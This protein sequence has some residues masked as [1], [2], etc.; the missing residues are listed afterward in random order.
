MRVWVVSYEEKTR[1]TLVRGSAGGDLPA[2][3]RFWIDQRAGT[4]LRTELLLDDRFQRSRIL[5]TFAPDERFPVA[6]PVRMEENYVPSGESPTFAMA[7]YGRFRRFQVKTEEA[8][9]S[10]PNP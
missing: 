9:K 1:P 10:P 5:T 6:V 4:V 7:T 2:H 8:L 3:G